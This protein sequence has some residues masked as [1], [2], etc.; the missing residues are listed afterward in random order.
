MLSVLV[1]WKQQVPRQQLQSYA[2]D[3]PHICYLVPLTALQDNFR[4]SVL[5]SADD[6]RMWL[7]EKSGSSEIDDPDFIRSR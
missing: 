2:P 3:G 6:S 4:R 1:R 7:V 5:P